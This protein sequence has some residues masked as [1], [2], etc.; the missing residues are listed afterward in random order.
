VKSLDSTL[1]DEVVESLS[2]MDAPANMETLH[3]LGQVAA[4]RDIRADHFPKAFDLSG[5]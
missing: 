4:R 1:D 2:A 3:R 5:A